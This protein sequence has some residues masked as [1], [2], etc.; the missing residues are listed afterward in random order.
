MQ[1]TPIRPDEVEEIIRE[2]SAPLYGNAGTGYGEKI[3]T[4][5]ML[6]L[7]GFPRPRRVYVRN[8]GNAGTAY[9]IFGGDEYNV[10]GVL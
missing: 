2:D 6:K 9:I 8:Y 4:S 10:E 1:T 7:K 5:Y 3:P